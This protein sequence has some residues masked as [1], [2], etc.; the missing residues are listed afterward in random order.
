MAPNPASSFCKISNQTSE[1]LNCELFS[2]NGRTLEKF[3]L[4]VNGNRELDVS[5][6]ENGVYYLQSKKGEAVSVQRIVVSH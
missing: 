4:P 5:G 2:A 3:S 6:F 1:L